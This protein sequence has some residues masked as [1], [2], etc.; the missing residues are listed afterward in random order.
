LVTEIPAMPWIS[1]SCPWAETFSSLAEVLAGLEAHAVV[2]ALDHA[3]CAAPGSLTR[4][5]R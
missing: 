3:R 4:D 2:V 1:T 5:R